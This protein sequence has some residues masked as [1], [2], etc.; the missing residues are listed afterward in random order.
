M[1]PNSWE[2]VMAVSF[3]FSVVSW[4]VNTRFGDRKKLKK[5]NKE[6]QAF[7]KELSEATKSGDKKKLKE[8]GKRD[9]EVMDKTREMMM[10]SFKPLIV[11]L[12]LFWVAYA[13]VLP[14]FFPDFIVDNLSFYL[15]S[16][17][18]FWEPWKNYLGARGLF[19]YALLVFGLSFQ[20][21]EKIFEK[22]RKNG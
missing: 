15:P 6:I 10:L 19:I 4:L 3:A 17:I 11:V 5:I 12:P 9:S 16:S 20:L 21:I 18:M 7:Q 13:F 1:I 8:L 14:A 22:V 2:G